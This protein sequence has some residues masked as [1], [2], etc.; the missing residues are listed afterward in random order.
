[1]LALVTKR[2]RLC[3]CRQH[4]YTPYARVSGHGRDHV[5]AYGTQE[6]VCCDPGRRFAK[7]IYLRSAPVLL[8]LIGRP[9]VSTKHCEKLD[10]S[11]RTGITV[12][13]HHLWLLQLPSMNMRSILCHGGNKSFEKV[14]GKFD[15]LIETSSDCES[16]NLQLDEQ[17]I[18]F[19]IVEHV[20]LL[21]VRVTYSFKHVES[22][23]LLH[24]R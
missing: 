3:A 8:K 18:W 23:P 1:M 20:M 15:A 2:F 13:F 24:Q 22:S 11:F 19:I 21:F 7:L 17:F 5:I 12:K 10:V 14:T 4:G 9:I 16:K 6:S